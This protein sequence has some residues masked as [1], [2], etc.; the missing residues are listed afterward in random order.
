MGTLACG[1]ER[2]VLFVCILLEVWYSNG[3]TVYSREKFNGETT[4]VRLSADKYMGTPCQFQFCS[5]GGAVTAKAVHEV[6]VDRALRLTTVVI[7]PP[8]F[9]TS[10]RGWFFLCVV[11]LSSGCGIVH[12]THAS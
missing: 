12:V 1:Y 9:K 2:R 6:D 3:G 4:N 10:P 8:I 7:A 11:V 5:F